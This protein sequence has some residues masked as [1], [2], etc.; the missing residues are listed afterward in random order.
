MSR[1]R[2]IEIITRLLED[3]AFR[4]LFIQDPEAALAPYDLPGPERRWFI[5]EITGWDKLLQAAEQLNVPTRGLGP[6][7]EGSAPP[8]AANGGPRHAPAAPESEV[9]AR[10]QRLV[11]TGFAADPQPEKPLPANMP[12]QTERDYYFWLEV[13]EPV[14]GAIDREPVALPDDLQVGARLQVAL[15]T[16]D[17]EFELVEGADVGEL[18]VQ[19][20]ETITVARPA[21][22]PP[23]LVGDPWLEK[24]LFFPV[25]T[26]PQAGVHHLRCNLY[27]RQ[28]LVQSH[29]VSMNVMASPQPL[30]EA[31]VTEAD[32]VLSHTLS[33]E[34]LAGMGSNRLSLMLN[35][36]GDGSHGFRF[37][38]E[39][40]F[41]SNATLRDG[42]V[43]DLLNMARAALRT[44]A[45]GT[46][47]EYTPQKKY[48][49]LGQIS[50]D[51]LGEDLIRLARAGYRFYATLIGRL[52]GD[53]LQARKLSQIML[54]TGQVQIATRQSARL[55]IPAAL[56][57]DYP[58]DANLKN[59][60]YKLCPDFLAALNGP[61]PLED[62]ACFQ[63][64]CPTRDALDVV[65]PSGFWGFRHALGLPVSIAGAPD[66][67]VQITC[68]AAAEM[69]VGVSLDPGFTEREKHAGALQKLQPGLG[70]NYA[71]SRDE[72]LQ[73]MHATRAHVV[74]FYCH[75]GL[76]GTIP[77]I[78]VGPKSDRGIT[79][80]NLLA[81]D[82]LWEEPRPLV[83][84]NGCH[85]TALEPD[86]AIDLVSAFV[87]NAYAA[88]VIGT[89]ITIFE[90]I[91]V[92][93]A[94][95]CL[96]RFLV[97]RQTIGE[98]V[99]GARLKMLKDKNPLGLVYIPYVMPSLKLV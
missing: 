77:Y 98:A 85:T 1:S 62:A 60:D 72:A 6:A 2:R 18:E 83:F 96:R 5:N 93:F 55:V 31:L 71:D 64:N 63:G 4:D 53:R 68:P 54:R 50:V 89:E 26:P 75:G 33:G 10:P 22:T 51:Q 35:D 58:L 49:Y 90:P 92:A 12:L 25:R 61:Q 84:I 46:A 14:A 73:M 82:I 40:E 86:S 7:M 3:E 57:Y 24:R 23:G 94:E 76:D 99:R 70:W 80:D 43:Q 59:S 88:G 44:A 21:A 39:A 13:G 47:E 95:E 32:Y 81:Y 37:F 36:N 97:D 19:P 56:F 8:V 34:Q 29:L 45:W 87:T 11:S 9:A 91:A 38:G 52:A 28:M 69:T 79:A 78:H 42:E 20:D 67:P 48:R 15:F 65:C 27:Y 17:S 30:D 74:Y 66:A 16:F 41:K